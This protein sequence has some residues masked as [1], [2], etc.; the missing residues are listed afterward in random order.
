MGSHLEASSLTHEEITTMVE[1]IKHERPGV[2]VSVLEETPNPF[3]IVKKEKPKEVVVEEEEKKVVAVVE[4]VK[5]EVFHELTAILNHAAFINGKWYKVGDKL[6][7]YHIK[8]IKKERV[9][10]QS[11]EEQKELKIPKRKKKFELHKGK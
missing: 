2:N 9:M 3:A 6:G 11:R 8:S 10:L 7:E 5:E 1:K 4:E